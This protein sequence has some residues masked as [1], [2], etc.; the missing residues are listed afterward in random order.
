M[1]QIFDRIT[2]N[3]AICMGQVTIRGMRLTVAFVLKLMASGMSHSEILQAYPE[4]ESAD[5]L[6]AIGYA[7]WLAEE[8]HQPHYR[9]AA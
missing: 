7:A 3:P 6:Q 5:L 2:V 4:L 9:I 1:S 8:Y